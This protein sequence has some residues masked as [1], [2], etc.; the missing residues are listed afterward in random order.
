MWG[1]S[2]KKQLRQL[3]EAVVVLSVLVEEQSELLRR[4]LQ[5]LEHRSYPATTAIRVTH[6]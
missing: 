6:A 1:D 5:A 3:E 4:I 2:E